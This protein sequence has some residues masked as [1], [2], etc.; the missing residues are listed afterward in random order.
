ML[1]KI[2]SLLFIKYM[3]N[4]R[5]IFLYLHIFCL[6]FFCLFYVGAYLYTYLCSGCLKSVL[7]MLSPAYVLQFIFSSLLYVYLNSFLDSLRLFL[8]ASLTVLCQLLFYTVGKNSKSFFQMC[9]I[10]PALQGVF[11]RV[12]ES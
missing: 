10:M 5:M 9:Q 2:I 8:C 7:L 6:V 3:F 11:K 4:L 12:L 1:D